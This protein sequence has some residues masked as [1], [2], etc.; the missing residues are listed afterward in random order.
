MIRNPLFKLILSPFYLL[1]SVMVRFRNRLYDTGAIRQ[2]HL[3]RPVVSIGNVTAGGT[4]KTPVTATLAT[5][6]INAGM[7]P[8]GILS[9]GY[10]RA[11]ESRIMPVEPDGSPEQFGDEP[12]LLSRELGDNGKVWVGKHRFHA[13]LAALEANPDTGIFLLD[14]GFQHRRLFR[15]MDIVL[16]DCTSP[17]GGGKLLPFGVLR[18][19]VE[20]IRRAHGVILTRSRYSPDIELLKDRVRK[21]NPDAWIGTADLEIVEFQD[22]Q[23]GDTLSVGSMKGKRVVTFAG[24]GN[25]LAF[26]ADLMTAGLD[27]ARAFA[28][29]DH[30]V[31]TPQRMDEFRKVAKAA[32]AQYIVTTAKDW[33]KLKQEP[34]PRDMPLLVCRA[35]MKLAQLDELLKRIKEIFD[36]QESD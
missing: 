2:R 23:T 14:D 13:G 8:V 9:R 28:L 35:E 5:R 17:F 26:K 34:I 11:D 15:D 1:Y 32:D 10:G 20:G 7:G 3:P 19:P 25:P 33:V 12:L 30:A 16:L 21:L 4:G 6:L 18:E 27:V 29:R 24:I 31:P 22:I 36:A